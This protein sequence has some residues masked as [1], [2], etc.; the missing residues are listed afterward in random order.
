[1]I[2]TNTNDNDDQFN[3]NRFV[4]AQEKVYDT[5]LSELRNGEKLTHWMWFIFPQI[6][7]LGI[8][9]TSKYYAI[10]NLE[11]AR[12]YLHHPVLGARLLECA[13]A[14]LAVQGSSASDIFGYPDYLKLKSSMTLFSSVADTDSVFVHI[15]DKY[16]NGE[17][18]MKTVELLEMQ[19][20]R[21]LR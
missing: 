1:M 7:G 8:T 6:E 2:K 19:K 4:I 21:E 3:L 15:L 12:Q 5:A 9:P 14:V 10:K 11:E 17:R 18:D 20:K 16:F 13:E